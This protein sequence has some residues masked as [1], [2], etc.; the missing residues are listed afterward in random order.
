MR[1]VTYCHEE[2]W[3]AGV[4]VGDLVVDA[5]HAPGGS[6]GTIAVSTRALLRSDPER[7]S[8]IAAAAEDAARSGT[9]VAGALADIE[10]GP[11]VRNPE[12]IFCL[13]LNYRDHAVETALDVEPV[14]TLFTKF[15]NALVGPGSPIVLSPMSDQV[16]FEGELALVIG[17]RGSNV[18]ESRALDYV[19]GYMP[20][21]DVSARDL[22]MST[23]QWTAGK[24]LDTFAPCGPTLVLS[25]EV[26][27]PQA[28]RISTRVNGTTLQSASTADM[29][30]GIAETVS[31][32]SRLVTLEVGDIIATGTP[33]GVGYTRQPPIFLRAGDTVEVEIEGLGTLSNP[34]ADPDRSPTD[35]GARA[36]S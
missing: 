15:R 35:R 7:R 9:G 2:E 23:S 5:A 8:E 20:F 28:L 22:Q 11:P 25:D 21:N 34:V 6:D 33:A 18:P 19:G 29:I 26:D 13:G 17:R 36:G 10:L 24:V 31:Y 12:K 4:L 32:V 27:D 14:P 16:D 30:F 3:R 1:L